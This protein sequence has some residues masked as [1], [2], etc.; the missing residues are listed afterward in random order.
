MKKRLS[1]AVAILAIL[2]FFVAAAGRVE[3]SEPPP[4][5]VIGSWSSGTTHAK[6]SGTNRA[7]VL[8][9]HAESSSTTAP[10][11]TGNVTYGGQIMTPVVSRSNS[12]GTTRTYTAAYI[13]NEAGITAATG[14]PPSFSVTWSNAASSVL[15]HVFLQN[16]NQTTLYGATDSN[17]T[18]SGNTITTTTSLAT[19]IGDM[20]IGAATNSS[21]GTYT[22]N[23]GFNKALESNLSN[24][25]S[26]DINKSATGVNETPSITHSAGVRQT[27][28]GF[29]AKAR[30][31]RKLTVS[32]SAGGTVTTP[33]IG[34]FN[35]PDGNNAS[36]VASAN[37]N[38][39]FV[40]WTGTAVTAGKVADPNSATTTVT[41]DANY[42][43]QANFA[44]DQRSLTTSVTGSGTITQPGIGSFQYGHGTVV[45]L[46]A[47]PNVGY[48]FV[49]WTGDTGTIANV[50]AAVTTITMNGDY[51]IQA[52]F[53]I[54]QYTITASAGPHGSVSPTSVVVNYGANQDFNA[55]P[56]TGYEVD[57]WSV[58]GGEV[59]MDGNT[60][61][62]TNVTATHVV[63]V[64]FKQ[65]QFTISGTITCAGL[66]LADANIIGL[67]VMTDVNGFYSAIFS[68]GWSGVVMPAKYGYTF[69]PN[70][71]SYT[72]VSSDQTAQDY[73]ALP[74]DDFDDNRRGRMWRSAVE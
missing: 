4:V 70:S 25:D 10:S 19:A 49:N 53:A 12:S 31:V 64:T 1:P 13:L 18:T 30:P 21:T 69:D 11:I 27:I 59:Q 2:T 51:V 63:S 38:Y 55:T 71:R 52:N 60:Y 48:H 28:V 45:D 15:D 29:V 61:T 24:G 22:A 9:A 73:N 57:K 26:A 62:L 23:N 43:V 41:M 35:Y 58:D 74:S 34:D 46:N 65:S 16:V 32:A 17:Q 42:A 56:D 36:I 3:A 40:N 68:S 39:H 6:E 50:D 7:L 67:G 8:L 66:A 14:S 37:A 44:I 72:N 54:N 33:G 20:V 47:V 5:S